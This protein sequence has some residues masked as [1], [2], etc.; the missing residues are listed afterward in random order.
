MENPIEQV[1]ANSD[2][3]FLTIHAESDG[4]TFSITLYGPGDDDEKAEEIVEMTGVTIAEALAKLE[5]Y[6]SRRVEY[7]FGNAFW[8]DVEDE[9]EDD[10][11]REDC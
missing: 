8:Q 7:A 6:V 2:E 1:L 10:A 11:A 4:E 5:A 9:K 3:S